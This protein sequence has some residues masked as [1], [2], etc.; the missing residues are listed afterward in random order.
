MY[1]AANR[2]TGGRAKYEDVCET[3]L[4]LYEFYVVVPLTCEFVFTSRLK[5]GKMDGQKII[6]DTKF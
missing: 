2:R 4:T 6:K 3:Q 5:L 1:R